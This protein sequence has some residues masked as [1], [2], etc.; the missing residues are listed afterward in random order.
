MHI[1]PF[2]TMFKQQQT[3]RYPQYPAQRAGTGPVQPNLSLASRNS[4]KVYISVRIG[5]S[6]STMYW[7]DKFAR[8]RLLT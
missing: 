4:V 5:G 8:Q 6:A 3:E 2:V 7:S 1:F